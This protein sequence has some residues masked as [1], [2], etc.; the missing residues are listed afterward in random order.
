MI[1]ND[2]LCYQITFE[3][4]RSKLIYCSH[5]LIKSNQMK[6]FNIGKEI[7]DKHENYL[8]TKVIQII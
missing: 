6:Q 5:D 1:S 2:L 3:P 7:F 4:F 8:N